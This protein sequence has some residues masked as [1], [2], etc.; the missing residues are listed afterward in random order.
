MLFI[1]FL[2]DD[3]RKIIS[4]NARI[5]IRSD[6]HKKTNKGKKD[7]KC[8]YI[9]ARKGERAEAHVMVVETASEILD[10]IQKGSKE[11]ASLGQNS[12]EKEEEIN[13]IAEI[14]LTKEKPA[15]K[16]QED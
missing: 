8:K 4:Y 6:E 1:G 15:L 14:K 5:N 9:M 13:G 11:L 12:I 3:T 2:A 7:A 16:V 10:M